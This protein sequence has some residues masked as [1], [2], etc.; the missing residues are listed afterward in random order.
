MDGGIRV[1]AD[2]QGVL[3]CICQRIQAPEVFQD[4]VG[5]SG[6]FEPWSWPLCAVGNLGD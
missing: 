1:Y 6:F 4:G 3:I 2:S 5:F